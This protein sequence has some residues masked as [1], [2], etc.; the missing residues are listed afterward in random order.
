M[1]RDYKLYGLLFTAIFGLI[2]I[3][4]I[5]CASYINTLNINTNNERKLIVEELVR[6]EELLQDI[7]PD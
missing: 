2:I 7:T 3:T 4:A 1:Q 6:I 5:V